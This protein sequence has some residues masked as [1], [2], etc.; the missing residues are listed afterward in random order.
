M[1]VRDPRTKAAVAILEDKYPFALLL[2]LVL[3]IRHIVGVWKKKLK[4]GMFD[5]GQW[6]T[7]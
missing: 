1:L 7:V 4:S 6:Y 3:A 5:N 2:F